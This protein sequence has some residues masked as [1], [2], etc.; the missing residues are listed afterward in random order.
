MQTAN[1]FASLSVAMFLSACGTDISSQQSAT[2][3][4]PNGTKK[5]AIEKVVLQDATTDTKLNIPQLK[6]DDDPQNLL[7]L[8]P[9]KLAD[10]LGSP[11]FVRRD[12]SAEVWQY[13]AEACILDIFLYRNKGIFAV[14]YVE[15]RARG[16]SQ[17]SR[18]DCY[19]EMLRVH[20]N[21]KQG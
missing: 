8:N 6:I 13:L 1:V 17:L 20:L 18:R 21:A 5:E 16:A 10:Q 12:G 3:A 15:L 19:R 4:V 11:G 9:R 2:P 7:G 14:D